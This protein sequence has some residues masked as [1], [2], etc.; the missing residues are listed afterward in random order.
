M[1]SEVKELEQHIEQIERELT[2]VTRTDPVVQQLHQI[3][4]ELAAE[5]EV[6][7]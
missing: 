1:L 4:Y 6:Q 3:P 7:H 5:H 2:L